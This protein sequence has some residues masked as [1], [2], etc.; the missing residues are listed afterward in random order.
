MMGI[1]FVM[2]SMPTTFYSRLT[3]IG[4]GVHY[5]KVKSHKLSKK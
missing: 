1:L 3:E 2:A 4:G 5:A